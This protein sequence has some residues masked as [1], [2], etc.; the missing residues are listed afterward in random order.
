MVIA[1][2][3]NLDENKLRRLQELKD[4]GVNPFP[5]TFHQTNHALDINQK[6]VYLKAEEKTNDVVLVAGRIMLKRVMGKASF[7]HLQD[8]TG[9]VQLFFSQEILGEQL[10]DLIIKKTDLGDLIGAEGKVFKTKKGEVTVLVS[11]AQ[12]LCKSL[13]MLP[14]KFH[15]LQ[16]T[17]LRLRQRY[18]DLIMN[19]ETKETFAKRSQIIQTVRD[20]FLQKK[21]LEVETPTLQTIYGGAKAKPF[22]THI[23]AWKMKMFLSISPELYLK[24]L[25]VGGFEKVFTICKNFR[26]EDVDPS[27]NPE[28]T[29]LEIYE[30]YTDYNTMLEYLEQVYEKA[31]LAVNGT[32][33]VKHHYQSQEVVIDFKAPWKK[34]TMLESIKE[35]AGIDLSGMNE[36]AAQKVVAEKKIKTEK[37]YSFLTWGECVQLLFE[38]LVEDKLIQP[39]HIIDHPRESTPLCKIHRQDP[40]LIER[41]E[42][43]CLGME[44]CNAY[45]ELNDAVLQRQLLEAQ[46]KEL[47]AGDEEAHPLDEDFLN[48]LEYG[49]PPAGGLGFGIDRMVVLLTGADSIREVIFFP[50]MKPLEEEKKKE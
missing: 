6:Y 29:M 45:S 9:K 25:L 42:S 23:N 38:E 3:V 27:H 8:Q 31:C 22:I 39:T 1:K 26:N 32:T 28:F 11:S 2:K 5:Y 43:F 7:M 30:A 18:L 24:R 4:S 16:E 47:T 37:N 40:R 10:Y 13:I 50:T 41:F 48:A 44:L 14:E 20:Y 35:Y 17:E 34:M 12:I 36:K 46:Q 21:F 19:P 33:K 15:G 49:M